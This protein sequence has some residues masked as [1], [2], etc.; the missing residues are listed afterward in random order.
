M[1]QTK[2]I[3]L[4]T[5]LL[6]TITPSL[7]AQKAPYDV[8]PPAEAPYYRVRYEASTNPGELTFPV[9]YTIWIP[10]DVKNLRGVIVHQHGC[11]EGSC[12]SG[13]TGAYDLHWQALAK[14]HDCAL[15]APSYE[16]PEKG[17]CQMWCD[18]RNGSSAAF[19]KCL[20]DLGAKSGHPELSK[21]PW[22]L[23]GHSGGGHWAGG[24]VL[25]HPERVAAAWLRS[26]VP[27]LKANA[28]RSTIKA[29][30]L[31]DAA[32]KVPV[33]C[34][35]G[36]KEGVTVKDSRFGGVWAANE[37]F[38]NEIRSKGGLI[39]VAVDPLSSHECGNQRYLAI[40]WL[41]ACLSARL[42]KIAT[43]PL[44]AMPT[45]QVWLAPITGSEAQPM[46]KFSG[47]PLKA[48]W[49]PNEAIAKSWMQYV[50]D[51]LVSDTSAPSAPT[52]LQV[53]GNELNWEAEADLESG[54]ASF[55][56]ER[57]GKFL[58]N[59]PETGKNPFG[60][61]I[62]QNLQ[63]S[64]TPSQPLVPMKYT[65]TKAEAGKKHTYRVITVNTAGLKSKPSSDSK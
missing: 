13:L 50:K 28:E 26:G 15:L 27:L 58:A 17:D 30:T 35:P 56:I 31:P 43:N 32:L 54:L 6:I 52:N 33:M 61:P 23:W 49:L 53:K 41:D 16:Q 37:T 2:F 19:Q 18:P 44:N 57:D 65:D 5:L 10:K 39:S 46:A 29:H 20:I 34:N 1:T 55:I 21:L 40:V 14:K 7:Y 3:W 48:A 62:F 42:P 12:K 24:M 9:N 59:L 64:D 11:G 60:R 51:T 36:T 25:M 45:D 22:A 8:F 47:E 63:Y 4:A 38:F